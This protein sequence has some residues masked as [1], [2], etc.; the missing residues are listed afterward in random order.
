MPTFDTPPSKKKTPDSSSML[1][2]ARQPVEPAGRA[3]AVDRQQALVPK[4][5]QYIHCLLAFPVFLFTIL[6]F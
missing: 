1:S 5:F 2:S 4:T 6:P 3:G